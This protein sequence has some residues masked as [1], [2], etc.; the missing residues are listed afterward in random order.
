MTPKI[1]YMNSL[2]DLNELAFEE[3]SVVDED[4]LKTGSLWGLPEKNLKGFRGPKGLFDMASQKLSDDGQWILIASLAGWFKVSAKDLDVGSQVGLICIYGDD[5]RKRQ[6]VAVSI[7]KKWRPMTEKGVGIRKA[8][9]LDGKYKPIAD[10][11][12]TRG[13]DGTTYES[14]V[15][16]PSHPERVEKKNGKVF[17]TCE[18]NEFVLSEPQLV[19][20]ALTGKATWIVPD[21]NGN[22]VFS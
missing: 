14:F 19:K 6:S 12:V 8:E 3:A 1:F 17:L 2:S 5:W 20:A 21:E 13:L 18:G 22:F 10:T 4:V 16:L 15:V 9:L 7:E 11:M